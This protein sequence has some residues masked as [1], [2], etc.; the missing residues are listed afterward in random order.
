MFLVNSDR[1]KCLQRSITRNV[2]A[3]ISKLWMSVVLVRQLQSYTY[4]NIHLNIL[5]G[6]FNLFGNSLGLLLMP[7]YDLHT[8]NETTS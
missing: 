4:K 7:L 1:L 5:Q 3:R 8:A 6:T 2:K